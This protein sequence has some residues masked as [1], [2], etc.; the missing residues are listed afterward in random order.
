MAHAQIASPDVKAIYDEFI[1]GPK[2]PTLEAYQTAMEKGR[3]VLQAAYRDY[4]R[5]QNV[6]AIA[7]PTTALPSRP[8]G[9]DKEVELNG[10]QVSTLFT[11]LRNTR[12]MTTTGIPGLSLPIGTTPSGLPVGL[13]FD[14]PFGEDRGLLSLAIAAE[15]IFGKLEPPRM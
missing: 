7:F 4:F 11:Y 14:A 9:Q 1:V 3:P 8:I 10:K 15:Q 12:P 2:A 5:S 13:E 6:V